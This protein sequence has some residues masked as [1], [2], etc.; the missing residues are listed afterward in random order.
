M[1]L[2]FR[3]TFY[4]QAY[5]TPISYALHRNGE[6]ATLELGAQLNQDFLL[7]VLLYHEAHDVR[8]VLY[9]LDYSPI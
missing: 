1:L 9:S 3:D 8:A 4:R 2:L 5:P 7:H 6:I